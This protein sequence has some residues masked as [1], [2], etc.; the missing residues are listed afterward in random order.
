ML[1]VVSA[2]RDRG[3]WP[4]LERWRALRALQ[5]SAVPIAEVG[6]LAVR[7]VGRQG[8][9][10]A[11]LHGLAGSSRYWTSEFDRLGDTHRL[12]VPDLLGFGRSAPFGRGFGPDDHVGALVECFDAL[13]CDEPM[14]VVGHSLG[15]LLA[16]RL[17]ASHPER[18]HAVVGFGAPLYPNRTV[19]RRRIGG[20]SLMARLFVLPGPFAERACEWVC[21][22]RAVAAR[23]ARWTHPSLPRVIAEDSVL[24]SWPSYSE[25]LERVILAAHGRDWLDAVRCSVR[26]VVGTDD[27]VVDTAFVMELATTYQNVNLTRWAGGHDLPLTNAR[28]AFLTIQ[29]V[30]DAEPVDR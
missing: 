21:D 15:A 14:T 12:V 23:F 4:R 9:P 10:I 7:V 27:P 28:Q 22:H 19:A 30:A 20:T 6:R 11:L 29:D 24:H 8:P 5:P 18:V 17:A 13:G 26:L 25:T 16:L 1:W 2:R 3:Q